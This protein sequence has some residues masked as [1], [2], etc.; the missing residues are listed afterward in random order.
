MLF[1]DSFYMF[2]GQLVVFIAILIVIL[3][4][5]I[6]ILGLLIARKNEIKFP[7]LN[8]TQTKDFAFISEN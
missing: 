8:Y 5:V 1:I 7:S 6:L 2:L 3:F 4:I